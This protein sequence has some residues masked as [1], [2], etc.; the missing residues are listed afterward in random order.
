M[1]PGEAIRAA[2]AAD[3]TVVGLVAARIYPNL[4][5]Q[6]TLPPAI[7]YQVVSDVPEN[8]FTGNASDRLHGCRVQV[9]CWSKTYLEAQTIAA[10]VDAVLSGQQ[11]QS[12]SIWLEARRDSYDNEAVLHRV[13]CDFAVWL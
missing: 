3:A 6:G 9:D 4:I 5:P 10:A 12:L 13:S 1:T 8:A 2:L 7:V 11:S